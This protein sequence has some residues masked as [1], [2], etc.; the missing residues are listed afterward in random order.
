VNPLNRY[1]SQSSSRPAEPSPPPV[2]GLTLDDWR[3]ILA[4]GK[5]HR[6][7]CE[8]IGGEFVVAPAPIAGSVTF[9]P[10]EVRVL[11]RLGLSAASAAAIYRVKRT[12]GGGEVQP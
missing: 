10:N 12:F 7:I 2:R 1:V 8:A 3:A 9:T 5:S 4:S 11:C 6:L